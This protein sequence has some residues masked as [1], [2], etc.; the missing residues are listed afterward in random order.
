MDVNYKA[1]LISHACETVP[2]FRAVI[3]PPPK[4]RTSLSGFPATASPAT[5]FEL[6]ARPL[7]IQHRRPGC[8]QGGNPAQ[9]SPTAGHFPVGPPLPVRVSIR[10]RLGPT[11]RWRFPSA[12]RLNTCDDRPRRRSG[13]ASSAGYAVRAPGITPWWPPRTARRRAPRGVAKLGLRPVV[14]CDHLLDVAHLMPPDSGV[15]TTGP[16]DPVV[17]SPARSPWRSRRREDS[18]PHPPGPRSVARSG[19][20]GT[21]LASPAAASS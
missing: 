18:A 15:G 4:R 3:R 20:D 7:A 19:F 5:S 1:T 14:D 17:I 21:R 6:T 12:A 2:G 13:A 9:P 11:S 8:R 16:A 10:Q